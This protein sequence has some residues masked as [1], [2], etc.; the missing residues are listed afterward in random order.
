[1]KNILIESEEDYKKF[2]K[3][4][5]LYRSFLF[6]FVEINI[7]NCTRHQLDD[8][9][10]ALNIKNRKKRIKYMYEYICRQIDQYNE[11]NEIRCEFEENRCNDC[12]HNWHENGCC[13]HCSYQSTSGCPTQNLSCKLFFCDYMDKHYK[14]LKFD[15]ILM[16]KL[17]TKREQAI[18]KGNVF[19]SKEDFLNLLYIG[20][21]LIY[22]IYSIIKIFRM[23]HIFAKEK[24]A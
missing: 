16:L 17:F 14:L 18:I 23:K 4:I 12:K 13:Y 9:M 1:M 10:I 19:C 3:F 11:D 22:S 24:A 5:P 20:S 8:I 21:Y 6:K 7:I 2:I 15:D